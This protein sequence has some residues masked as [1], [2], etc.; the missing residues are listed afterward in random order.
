[1]GQNQYIVHRRVVPI[2][3]MAWRRYNYSSVVRLERLLLKSLTKNLSKMVRLFINE[4]LIKIKLPTVFKIETSHQ[5]SLKGTSTITSLIFPDFKI[6][7][8]LN[9]E[10]TNFTCLKP[11]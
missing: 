11:S 7:N 10:G 5:G 6:L 3:H 9:S 2:G 4:F 1:M 8:S